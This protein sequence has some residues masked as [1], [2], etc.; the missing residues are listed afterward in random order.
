MLPETATKHVSIV[1]VNGPKDG[2]QRDGM[3]L[4]IIR[5]DSMLCMIVVNK[6]LLVL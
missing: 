4:K 2:K 1:H 5:R 6:A 3:F